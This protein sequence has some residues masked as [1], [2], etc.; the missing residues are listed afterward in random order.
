M[1]A[2]RPPACFDIRIEAPK[3]LL[4]MCIRPQ[5]QEPRSFSSPDYT[6][7]YRTERV[8]ETSEM[9]MVISMTSTVQIDRTYRAI[10]EQFVLVWRSQSMGSNRRSEAEALLGPGS[11][12]LADSILG[13]L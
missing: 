10:F 4:S 12:L 5:W 7:S 3:G 8:V 1:V 2:R 13:P 6:E 9:M 11:E